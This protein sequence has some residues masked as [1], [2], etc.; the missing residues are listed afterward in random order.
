MDVIRND[1]L[2]LVLQDYNYYLILPKFTHLDFIK[3]YFVSKKTY[4]PEIIYR[5]KLIY[6]RNVL[7]EI[8]KLIILLNYKQINEE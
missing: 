6:Y 1:K 7:R 3:V 4:K 2:Y 8:K 5:T